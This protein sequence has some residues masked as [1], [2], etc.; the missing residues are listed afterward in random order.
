M[1]SNTPL[2]DAEV[3]REFLNKAEPFL[4]EEYLCRLSSDLEL[5]RRC[6]AERYPDW[7]DLWNLVSATKRLAAEERAAWQPQLSPMRP[8]LKQADVH[9][10]LA[11]LE[12][13]SDPRPKWLVDW[14]TFWAHAAN[15]EVVWWA[16]WVYAPTA[17]T[18]ALLLLLDN[19]T[20]LQG[21]RDLTAQYRR[22]SDAVRFLKAVLESTRSLDTVA[23]EYRPVVTLAV[24]YTVYMFTMASWKLTE[25]FTQVLP[26][27]PT[28]VRMVLGLNRWEGK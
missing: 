22:V 6:V 5:R 13:M 11:G 7:P 20:V 18:G 24:V 25:E 2:I 15:P 16:R 17:E 23:A 9:A 1:A 21:A 26:P 19:P 12:E 27:F 10:V 8:L 4:T 14:A 28:V 3:L